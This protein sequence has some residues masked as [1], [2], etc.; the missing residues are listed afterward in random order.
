MTSAPRPGIRILRP[1]KSE[2]A[3]ISFWNQPPIWVP[4]LP[5][6]KRL[7]TEFTVELIPELLAAAVVH[8]GVVLLRN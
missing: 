2:R 3:L 6:M 4:V 8:L 7:Q 1:W 5:A